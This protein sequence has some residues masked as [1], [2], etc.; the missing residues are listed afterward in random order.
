ML[1]FAQDVR[2]YLA[3]GLVI[4]SAGL[5]AAWFFQAMENFR[6]LMVQNFVVKLVGLVC[7]FCFVRDADDLVL[8]ILIQAGSTLLSNL[9][10]R[11][12]LAGVVVRVPLRQL[13]FRR[14]L[15][16]TMVYF[17]PTVAT[18]VYTVLDRTMIGLLT[19]NLVESGFYEQAHKIVNTL[20]VAI[21]S[22]NVV[23]GVRT[24]Y[25]FGQNRRG[26]IRRHIVSTFRFMYLL[27]FPLAA[28][29]AACA[30]NFVPWFYGK[31]Y[32]E[33]APLL[34]MFAPLLFTIG[35]SNVLGNLYL[36]PSGR[37]ALSNRAIIA[38]AVVNFLLNLA[39]IPFIGAYGAVI[40]S[41]AAESCIAV[42]YLRYSSRF[43]RVP[44]ILGLA[45]RYAALSAVM[46]LP[47]S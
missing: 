36:T 3:C 20:L 19:H 33:V 47:H 22:L 43:I 15:R 2:V 21:T 7:V 10:M 35:T 18:S 27:S 5:D 32:A 4:L 6:T 41:V 11:L 12:R 39:L 37:R 23:V 8:Y 26:E 16:E 13:R 34:V 24:S 17:I 25:L 28:G 46:F 31:E 42:L 45:L 44:G 40:A 30:A 9:L 38:G 1:I 14:H 29:L